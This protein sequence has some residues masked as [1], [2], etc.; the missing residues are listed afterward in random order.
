MIKIETQ[1]SFSRV[2]VNT[3]V[4]LTAY[5]TWFTL[6]RCLCVSGR[7]HVY[8][9]LQFL[10]S[11][12]RNL[13]SVKIAVRWTPDHPELTFPPRFWLNNILSTCLLAGVFPIVVAVCPM[14]YWECPQ[15]I[16]SSLLWCTLPRTFLLT[17]SS[18]LVDFL[19]PHL[20]FCIDYIR[21]CC[22]WWSLLTSHATNT[23][24]NSSSIS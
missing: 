5:V 7:L 20:S 4:S 13:V 19:L 9:L 23:V 17:C 10:P 24:L 1:D 11:P 6:Q 14:H 12:M 16:P 8:S 15:V 18:M 3:L 2:A 22:L 21:K